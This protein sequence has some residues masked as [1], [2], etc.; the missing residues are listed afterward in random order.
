[1]KK[2]KTKINALLNRKIR[3]F[4]FNGDC[5]DLLSALPD[6]SVQLIITSPPYNIG[7]S[8]ERKM[9][10]QRYIEFQK[11]VIH[12]CVRVLKPE[13]NICWQVGNFVE[14]AS[15]V[16]LDCA[17]FPI[18]MELGLK[19]RNRIIWHFGHGL[20]CTKR[21]SGRHE[22]ICWFTKTDNY[23]FNLDPI[24]VPQKYP[25]KTY[26]KGPRAGQLSCNPL[27]KNPSDVWQIPNVKYKHI[28]KTAH[29][30][31]FPVELAERLVL[32]MSNEGDIVFDP[33]LGSG[34]TSIAAVR[35]KRFAIGADIVDEY[36]ELAESRIKCEIET[37]LRT[38]PMFKKIQEKPIRMPS[39]ANS[40]MENSSKKAVVNFKQE[41]VPQLKRKT[42]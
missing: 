4:V 16:P 20:H 38:R 11:K 19:M 34:S 14:N 37:G 41:T 36:C 3:Y 12:E 1:M 23:V 9:S 33:F 39:A 6:S 27:G 15:V 10:L 17:L 30:C 7:K 13:G 42:S 32:S 22:T 25:D 29:P 24:R 8:Y 40:L 2:S 26:F 18:F 5:M 28:E 35:Y 21:F 31:Q